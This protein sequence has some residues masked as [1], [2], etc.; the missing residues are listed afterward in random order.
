MASHP[1][2][3]HCDICGSTLK[4]NGKTSAGKTRY[5]CKGCGASST[6]TRSGTLHQ[7]QMKAF[8]SWLLGNSRD[9]SDVSRTQRRLTSWCWQVP[10]PQPYMTDKACILVMNDGTFFHSWCLIVAY[11]NTHVLG[12]QWV[13]K[14]NKAA[15]T[16]VYT[17]FPRP[18]A[19]VISGDESTAQAIHSIWP[20]VPIRRCLS[21]IKESVY[22][23]TSQAPHTQPAIEIKNLTESLNYVYTPEQAKLWLDRYNSWETTWKELLKH[24]TD[25]PNPNHNKNN[26]GWQ[27]THKE[28]R[29]IRLMYRTLIKKEEL[30]FQFT[31]PAITISD[32][33]LPYRTSHL[34]DDIS[35]DIKN[36]FRTHRGITHEHARRMVE[37]YLNSK[38]EFPFIPER[39]IKHEHWE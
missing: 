39:I 14:D 9:K 3:H 10:V 13:D 38:T 26:C 6:A 11:N 20:G 1:Y 37:W 33:A 25:S 27:W 31:E 7:R 4:K 32:V 35:A 34:G 24:R 17:Y 29:S 23:K 30:F 5:R 19:V 36:L 18:S 28:L 2:G 15:C 12:W 22:R 16:Q 8:I 21:R